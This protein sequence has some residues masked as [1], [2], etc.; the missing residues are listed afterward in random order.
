MTVGTLIEYLKTQQE[1]GVS[2]VYLDNVARDTIR[3]EVISRRTPKPVKEERPPIRR[4]LE[5]VKPERSATRPQMEE[6]PSEVVDP[7]SVA[8]S[9]P[10][11]D[12]AAQI[13]YLRSQAQEWAPAKSLGTLR[14]KM[15]FSVGTPESKIVLIGDSPGFEEEL[16]QEPFVGKAGQK[17]DAILKAMKLKREDLYITNI[18]KFRP[19]LPGQTMNNRKPNAQEMASCMPFTIKELEII[20]PRCILALGASA[21]EALT[22]QQNTPVGR[23][24]GQWYEFQ[25]IP[26]RV[27]YHP[28]YLLRNENN[29]TEKRKLWEDM[30]AVMEHLELPISEK[31]RGYFKAASGS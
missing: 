18:C 16:K 20:K 21:A 7:A 25:G 22:G 17:L 23:M 15:V 24:R 28:S 13:S 1:K 2:H 29:L 12:K 19:S 10:A 3:N 6:I 14:D 8:L 26:L 27:T 30:L 4:A 11:G 5:P 31:Q 9:L